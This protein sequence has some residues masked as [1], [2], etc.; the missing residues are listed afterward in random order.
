MQLALQPPDLHC[1][2]NHLYDINDSGC[3][4]SQVLSELD[5]NKTGAPHRM[6]KDIQVTS[7]HSLD[8]FNDVLADFDK[9]FGSDSVV[10]NSILTRLNKLP[11]ISSP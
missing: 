4:E 10:T 3:N 1:T 11:K 5:R 8:T 6:V 7:S 2:R 9:C